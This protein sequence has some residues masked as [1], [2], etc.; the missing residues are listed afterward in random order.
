MAT[1]VRKVLDISHHNDVSSWTQIVN[2]GI[3]GIIH[4]ATEGTS[5]TDDQY[6]ERREQAES[7][8]L[9]WGAYHFAN[10][11]NVQA[12]VDHFLAV[13]G[14]DDSTLYA[15]DWEDDPD[16]NTMSADQA[17][18]F[19]ELIAECIGDGRCVIYS[20]NVAKEKLGNRADPFFG[21][22]RLWLCQY[23]SSNITVQASW[24]DCWLWQYSD[25][26]AGP[27]PHGC[28]G[29][30][31]DVDTN[32]YT[33]GD[34]ELR[35]TW[36][37]TGAQP[38]PVPP[39]PP[40]PSEKT[41]PTI[42]QG[43]YGSSVRLV[44]ESLNAPPFDSD[45]GP[46]TK[47][48]VMAYQQAKRLSADGV[49]GPQTWGQLQKDFDLPPYPAPFLPPLPPEIMREIEDAA[50]ASDVADLDWDD[51]GVAPDGFVLGMAHAYVT[52]VQKFERGDGS[53]HEMAKAATGSSSDDALVYYRD[54]MQALGMDC[55]RTG[56]RTLRY[57][58][59][60]LMGLGMRESSGQHCCG[61]DTSAGESSQSS[62]TCEAGAWQTSHNYAVCCTD[63]DELLEEYRPGL[64]EGPS[65]PQCALSAFQKGVSCDAGDWE[66]VGSGIG[67]DFQALSKECPQF[68]FESA[69]IGI[70]NIRAHWG[71]IGRREVQISPEADAM[72][73]E[74]DAILATA[75]VA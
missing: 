54:T 26:N 1:I 25:G 38:E 11:S 17:R 56:R 64:G 33:E 75:A 65:P 55:S 10:G 71:P 39:T 23:S 12:Q 67:R 41:R 5:Y 22:H 8:G 29:V 31:G 2:A 70:R 7:V 57:V 15:L 50:L 69:A 45:F 42:G 72:F 63:A 51:R 73:A 21:L 52:V 74:I 32:S 19:L 24:D 35:S 14:V 40:T 4:K 16:G 53:A 13:V 48:A 3:V 37:G 47:N 20:G 60:F 58:A 28:P 59:V 36:S 62:D 9:L 46:K 61:R 44:Q 27:G 49:I 68:A 6:A 66:N 43:D 34:D 30:S 18:Q